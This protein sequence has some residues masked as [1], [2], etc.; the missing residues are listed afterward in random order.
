[1]PRQ[2]FRAL[3]GHSPVID[4]DRCLNH[5]PGVDITIASLKQ[6]EDWSDTFHVDLYLTQDD[7]W[8]NA[9]MSG[10]QFVAPPHVLKDLGSEMLTC[11]EVSPKVALEWF[12]HN[13][14][15]P[16]EELSRV[17][18]PEA[19]EAKRVADRGDLLRRAA[20]LK[21]TVETMEKE[22]LHHRE[23]PRSVRR[24]DEKGRSWGLVEVT[25]KEL[26]RTREQL[27]QLEEHLRASFADDPGPAGGARGEHRIE[28]TIGDDDLRRL[29][30]RARDT[31]PIVQGYRDRVVKLLGSSGGPDGQLDEMGAS[32][33][34]L[35]AQLRSHSNGTF[36]EVPD[37]SAQYTITVNDKG[38]G[39][40]MSAVNR[41]A[42]WLLTFENSARAY[43][44]SY[45]R[46]T[47]PFVR[48]FVITA[49]DLQAVCAPG[50]PEKAASSPT[51]PF[52]TDIPLPENVTILERLFNQ[53]MS[54]AASLRS[55]V[56]LREKHR[57][58]IKNAPT[59]QSG[60][61]N[62]PIYRAELIKRASLAEAQEKP[63]G[64]LVLRHFSA[65]TARKVIEAMQ[66]DR[67]RERLILDAEGQGGSWEHL[68]L[69]HITS[70]LPWH[71]EVLLDAVEELI[72]RI[73]AK[74]EEVT[75]TP[76][77][78]MPKTSDSSE[79]HPEV[80]AKRAGPP[81]PAF[82]TLPDGQILTIAL[83]DSYRDDVI[84]WYD[85]KQLIGTLATE[86]QYKGP[87][88]CH[89]CHAFG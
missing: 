29:A 75:K 11:W 64:D 27:A 67:V 74:L 69:A 13:H 86:E 32:I 37:P 25:E 45:V 21:A 65:E 80:I 33:R 41:L 42:G 79:L 66:R 72:P 47:A 54:I 18:P 1:M 84:V 6:G 34:S 20:Y 73:V 40:Q 19:V 30:D 2:Y 36:P 88:H 38:C 89:Q 60:P 57:E 35:A 63:S 12:R 52:E 7:R 71:D 53:V 5:W 48:D 44:H 8:V 68:A 61:R 59:D 4:T 46:L 39:D 81:I 76:S 85:G 62:G 77:V 3:D 87:G 83:G 58:L 78:S 70:E 23:H 49:D 16:P 50:R 26:A 15:N 31:I 17:A 10:D 56:D 51:V 82:Q 55:R 28:F 9:C 14:L 24:I 43:P 22:L